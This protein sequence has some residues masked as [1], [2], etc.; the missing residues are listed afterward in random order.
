MEHEIVLSPEKHAELK[1]E[2]ERLVGVERAAI[3]ERI[4]QARAL[5]DLS[6][7]FDYQDAK[8]QQGFL[9]GRIANVKG[10]L[11]RARVAVYETGG[12]VVVLG[13][14]VQLFDKEFDEEI[15]YTL[16]GPM[17]TDPA[18]C[19]ISHT[20]PVGQA[21]LGKKVGDKVQVPV[22][23]GTLSYEIIGIL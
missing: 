20:S 23:A 9:E 3:A 15:E 21:L 11:D 5:G 2:L 10:I 8:R 14:V 18:Q 6:E 16:V 12:D 19:R 22:P 1:A 13:S 17:E 7:N 4:R